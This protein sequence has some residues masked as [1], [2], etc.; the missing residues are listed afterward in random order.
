MQDYV[1]WAERIGEYLAKRGLIEIESGGDIAM[2]IEQAASGSVYVAYCLAN[3]KRYHLRLSDHAG[4][5]K[6]HYSTG[7]YFD[8]RD[9]VVSAATA[10]D[11][12]LVE[13][14]IAMGEVIS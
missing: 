7:K 4:N 3:N 6:Y 13:T 5:G 14:T 2:S 9:T 12:D 8:A 11:H 10:T 1:G